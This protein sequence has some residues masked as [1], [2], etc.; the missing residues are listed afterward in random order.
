VIDALFFNSS[1]V[2]LLWAAGALFLMPAAGL[3]DDAQKANENIKE[4]SGTAE[5]L[6][7]LPKRFAFL[8]GV[9]PVRGRATLLIEG[10]S[11]SKT[12]TLMPDAEVKVLGWWG[13]LDQFPVGD[14]VWVWFK[15]DRQ[16]Q[17]TAIAMLADEPS[18]QDIHGPG[19]TV[20]ARAENSLTV[21]AVGQKSKRTV[22]LPS[23]ARLL[24]GKGTVPLD[25]LRPGENVY[26]QST[27][28][29]ARL[30]LD[31]PAFDQL[32]AVQKEIL[33]R[34]WSEQ[35]LP[36]TVSFLHIFSGEMDLLLDHEAMRWGRSLKLGDKVTLLA[37]ASGEDAK[38]RQEIPAVV[39]SVQPWRER[40]Q[41]RLVVNG[42]DQADLTIGQRVGLRMKPPPAAVDEALLP[43]DL[44]LSRTKEERVEWFLA[45]IYCTCG[46]AGD[47]CTGHFYTLASC[48]PNGCGMPHAMRKDLADKIDRGLSDRQIFEALLKEQGP[49]LLHPHLMP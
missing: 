7:S 32:Q 14:R 49:N 18:E 36:G 43:P 47:I 8:Q 44:G 22:K 30:I 27:A 31:R 3:A 42:L 28:A 9:D 41:L 37:T 13:R 6:R 19:L 35:G 33:R 17:P 5:F 10:E 40:T 20:V 4:V 25:S 1:R 48:N 15:T 39:K 26:L 11:L 24:R 23:A 34:R 46:I 45:S 38:T 29:G 21:Q 2:R 12:W 16:K